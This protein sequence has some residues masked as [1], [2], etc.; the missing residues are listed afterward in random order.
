MYY[1]ENTTIQLKKTTLDR[2]YAAKPRVP[3]DTFINQLLDTY[4]ELVK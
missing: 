4:E 1:M 3:Y 2:L